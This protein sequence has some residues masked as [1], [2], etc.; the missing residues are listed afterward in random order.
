MDN[1]HVRGILKIKNSL[2]IVSFSIL[3]GG[4]TLVTN[5]VLEQ[6]RGTDWSLT[7]DYR[8]IENY[9]RNN[10]VLSTY[11]LRTLGTK[12]SFKQIRFFCHKK[13][14]GRTFDIA[15]TTNSSGNQLVQY[16]TAQTNIFPETCGSY[17]RLSDDNSKLANQCARCG[18]QSSKYF[19]GKWHHDGR[20]IAN[21]LVDHTAFCYW[22]D[23][24]CE[25]EFEESVNETHQDM[26]YEN[27]V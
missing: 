13:I 2:L 17:Y 18:L 9:T 20:V 25:N 27:N 23:C 8:Q 1:I 19:V 6:P 26:P 4:W 11:G 22:K 10:L 15:T 3:L 14:P 16:F 7:E 5:L 24:S 21:R 12:L